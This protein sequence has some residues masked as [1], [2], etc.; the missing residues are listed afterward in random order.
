VAQILQLYTERWTIEVFFRQSKMQLELD[1]YQVRKLQA[2]KRFFL[3]IMIVYAYC[4]SLSPGETANLCSIRKSA[5]M[6]I[7]REVV[8]RVYSQALCGVPLSD[9]NQELGI[10]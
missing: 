5:R 8:S 1:R 10:G 2:I 4:D 9:I 3:L 7:K 6:E